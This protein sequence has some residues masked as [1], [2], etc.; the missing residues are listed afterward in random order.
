[1]LNY[2]KTWRIINSTPC[3]ASYN[4]ALDE[5][6]AVSVR[7]GAS[8]PTLRLYSWDRPS[9]SLGRF[10]KS[11]D[12]NIGYCRANRIQIVKRPTGGRAI[13][14]GDELTYSFSVRTD[15]E[16]F[17][18]GLL[19]SYEKI[20]AAFNLALKKLGIQAEAKKHREKGRVLARSPLCF[21]S[22]SFGEILIDKKKV[23]GS[24][25]KRWP[26]SL[27]QQGSIPY[28][29][30][31][32]AIINAFGLK[33]SQKIKQDMTGLKDIIPDLSDEEFRGIIKLSFEELFDIKFIPALPSQ[34]EEALAQ[35]LEAEKY[36]AFG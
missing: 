9:L 27:L 20:S 36:Q 13:L 22:S 25:Q 32:A 26:D 4:M 35:K 28:I 7:K 15:Y 2:H 6:L 14:H 16:P 10:Q 33:S 29:I 21:Q 17:S 19:D 30:D 24:A 8:P 11:S 23:I 31:E 18:K 34:V 1:M 12:I 3:S 5:A